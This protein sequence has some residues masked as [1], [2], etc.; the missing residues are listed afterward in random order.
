MFLK[1]EYAVGSI[2]SEVPSSNWGEKLLDKTRLILK[3]IKHAQIRL[4]NQF[5]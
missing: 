5:R 4:M 2:Q 1:L 3:R